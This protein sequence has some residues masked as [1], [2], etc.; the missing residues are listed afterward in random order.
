MKHETTTKYSN[1]I[2]EKGGDH[3]V[4]PPSHRIKTG[5]QDLYGM[6]QIWRT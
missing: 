2:T 3:N 5:V 1:L 6:L 4:R